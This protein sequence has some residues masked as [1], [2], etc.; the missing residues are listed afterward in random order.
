[1]AC[2]EIGDLNSFLSSING[3]LQCSSKA[4]FD[5]RT[6]TLKFTTP[7]ISGVENVV[8]DVF[9]SLK[10]G[11]RKIFPTSG[12]SSKERLNGKGCFRA[13]VLL[14]M[15]VKANNVESDSSADENDGKPE[16]LDDGSHDVKL[17]DGEGSSGSG[18]G[19]HTGIHQLVGPKSGSHEDIESEA[20]VHVKSNGAV[21]TKSESDIQIVDESATVLNL[22]TGGCSVEEAAVAS[23]NNS[24]LGT[25]LD[26]DDYNLASEIQV[27][28]LERLKAELQAHELKCG[29][30]L[31]EHASRLFLL[32]TT[33]VSK[34]PKKLLQKIIPL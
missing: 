17:K 26:L 23:K 13:W 22:E 16:V 14:V 8:R 33:P 15:M 30:M 6:A 1:M 27:L 12:R 31:Q 21:V 10:E 5:G 28:G 3:G 2:N 18:S 25:P 32:Q 24:N 7:A 34:L 29:G 9:G 11:K 4:L 19:V 20:E